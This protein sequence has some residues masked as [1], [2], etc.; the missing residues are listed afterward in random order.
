MTG[1]VA[2]RDQAIQA[3]K[4]TLGMYVLDRVYEEVDGSY[5]AESLLGSGILAQDEGSRENCN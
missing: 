2:R 3:S 1:L 4:P 5:F